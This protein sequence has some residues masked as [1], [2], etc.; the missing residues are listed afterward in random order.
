[1]NKYEQILT[2]YWGYPTF[3]PL[4]EE[5]IRSV[6]EGNDTL[7]LLPT[8]GGKSITFQVPALIKEGLC[9]VVTPLIAL[10][11]DQVENL[12]RRDIKATLI[13]SGLTKHEIDITLN[14]CIYGDYKF[15]YVSPE[16][17]GTEIFRS[18][19]K[20]M[21]INLLAIDESH[22]I[23]QWGYDFR[24]S[25]LRIAEIREL[26]PD[27]PVLAVTATATP[28]VVD[29]IQE[30]LLFKSK[31][32]LQK[33]FERKNLI[34]VVREVEDKAKYI[35]KITDKIKG[36]GIIYV[37]SRGK[38]KKIAAFLNENNISADY[39]HAGLSNEH[40][41][42]KQDRWKQGKCRVMVATN[43]F[44]MGIDKADVR[45]VIHIDLPD[46]L[47]EY[48]QEAGRAG[49]DLKTAYAAL[50]FNEA[51]IKK[52]EKRVATTF[53]PIE[54]IK[55]IYQAIGNFFQIPF[56]SGKGQ[57]YDFSIGE[58]AR[59]YQLPI[60]TVYNSLKILQKNGYLEMTETVFVPSKIL[61]LVERDDLYKFQVAN[62][63]FD[64]F[65]KL[66]LRSYSGVFT[67]YTGIDE[68]YLAQKAKTNVKVIY[69]YLN[70]LKQLK[71]I[72]Y[73]PQRKNPYIIF[74]ENRL[75]DKS[76]VI[77]KE[78][79][80][81]RKERYVK[82]L[83]SVMRYADSTSK[84]RSQILLAYFGQPNANRCGKCDVCL[85][86]NEL[87]LSRYEFDLILEY[88]KKQLREKP[89]L[90]D[91]VVDTTAKKLQRAVEI[92]SKIVKVIQWLLDNK[93]IYYNAQKELE[94][95][96]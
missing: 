95:S 50:L 43:A 45:F 40:R 59:H 87:N 16:R 32:V 73:I 17:L 12:R 52:A 81:Q 6:D 72:N 31:N 44:G 51:D 1:M 85:R 9:I 49:R 80:K 74:T 86:R 96:T 56:E 15:L 71:I 54:T 76:V 53:P 58:F 64:A 4:Q 92:E 55:R 18:R 75:N 69:N 27:V 47:E 48:F 11:K 46:S 25:Y 10:M 38:T 3:R 83:E 60:L 39:Y 79:Y 7:A 61:F 42:Y 62:A 22:C 90:L 2:K 24:P 23:S 26:L 8:G 20:D 28:D 89:M 82:R 77:S 13:Y 21:N 33:S 29:D 30:K 91:N 14:N 57:T 93:K 88:V 19:V 5:I 36:T 68:N 94:W 35:L 65:I 34:Y 70:K 37:R 41:D 84:C 63:Q 66:V 67:D 78:S